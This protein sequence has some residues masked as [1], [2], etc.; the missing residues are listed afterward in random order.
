MLQVLCAQSNI[1]GL[2]MFFCS[3]FFIFIIVIIIV[4]LGGHT[5]SLCGKLQP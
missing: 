3:I 4:I 5:E 1:L 2:F